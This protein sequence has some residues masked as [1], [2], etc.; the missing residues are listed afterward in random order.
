VAVTAQGAARPASSVGREEWLLAVSELVAAACSAQAVHRPS[1]VL[2]MLGRAQ[3][4]ESSSVTFQDLEIAIGPTLEQFGRAK[5]AEVL[6]PFWHLQSAPFWE[7]QDADALPRRAGKDRPTRSALVR[8]RAV[9]RV[10]DNWWA[11]LASADLVGALGEAILAG[12]WQ[13]AADQDRVCQLLRFRRT[14]SEP[15]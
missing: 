2:F 7:V 5:K 14:R 10:K 1:L 11:C 8:S 13:T 6:L 15:R 12:L 3:R 9:G 4:R